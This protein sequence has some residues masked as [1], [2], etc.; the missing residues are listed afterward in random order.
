MLRLLRIAEGLLRALLLGWRIWVGI[1]AARIECAKIFSGIW[2]LGA[3][4]LPGQ[5]CCLS[6]G[7]PGSQL[8]FAGD[9]RHFCRYLLS[10][11][12]TIKFQQILNFVFREMLIVD[13]HQLVGH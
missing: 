5:A 12:R 7:S 13:S 10:Q 8:R 1:A 2:V 6:A 11:W 9:L 4:I 3:K